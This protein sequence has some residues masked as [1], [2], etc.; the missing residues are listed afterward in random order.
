MNTLKKSFFVLF[1]FV[2]SVFFVNA[3]ANGKSYCVCV[4]SFKVKANAISLSQNLKN[5]GLSTAYYETQKDGLPLYRVI[6]NYCFPSIECARSYRNKMENDKVIKAFGLKGLW[7]C[8]IDVQSV[9]V[10]KQLQEVQKSSYQM[11]QS[12]N[13]MQSSKSETSISPEAKVVAPVKSESSVASDSKSDAQS[14]MTVEQSEQKQVSTEQTADSENEES[15]DFDEDTENYEDEYDEA[16]EYFDEEMNDENAESNATETASGT[17]E[18]SGNAKENEEISESEEYDYSE[19]EYD[20]ADES[21]DVE[22]TEKA[23]TPQENENVTET[24]ERTTAGTETTV[25]PPTAE[26]TTENVAL[27][28]NAENNGTQEVAQ[29]PEEV[30]LTPSIYNPETEKTFNEFSTSVNFSKGSKT[31]VTDI[32]DVLNTYPTNKKLDLVFVLDSTGSMKD[33]ADTL[34]SDFADI[35]QAWAKKYKEI[36]IGMVLYRDWFENYSYNNIPVK[37]F[38]F[39]SIPSEFKKYLDAYT[40]E[41]NE[42]GDI[43]DAVYEGLYAGIT[44]FKWNKSS[45][46][47]IVLIGDAPPLRVPKK[48]YKKDLIVQQAE[49]NKI[50]IDAIITPDGKTPEERDE[51]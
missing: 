29:Q 50:Q 18:I 33:V 39:K 43:P 13:S 4:G 38:D 8:E 51:L 36:R 48:I 45:L 34:R 3:Q 27:T 41:G 20:Y 10:P 22:L 49:E 14:S 31:I 12:D 21:E 40:I 1:V 37:F 23:E 42:G 26:T 46:H 28:E 32:V 47:K 24:N 7:V 6:L 17:N 2:Y 44:F 15:Y 19:E 35:L 16:D 9:N 5:N 11:Q 25:N 30:P